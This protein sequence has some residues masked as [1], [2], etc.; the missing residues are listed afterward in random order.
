MENRTKSFNELYNESTKEGDP[1][2]YIVNRVGEQYGQLTITAYIE[3]K[4][5]AH[6]RTCHRWKVKC[7]CGK[8]IVVDIQQL[9]KVKDCGCGCYE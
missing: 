3:T 8:S 6:F 4:G 2:K 1:S 7:E 9:R 5:T